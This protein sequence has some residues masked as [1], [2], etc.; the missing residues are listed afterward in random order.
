MPP[1]P[2]VSKLSFLAL[3]LAAAACARTSPT[4]PE[5][6]DVAGEPSLETVSEAIESCPWGSNECP[7]PASESGHLTVSDEPLGHAEV[8]VR[9]TMSGDGYFAAVRLALSNGGDDA[10][11]SVS[12]E[13]RTD[14]KT[15]YDGTL[16]ARGSV[17]VADFAESG[18]TTIPLQPAAPVQRLVDGRSY[19]LKVTATAP[20]A[21]SALVHVGTSAGE[22]VGNKLVRTT[23]CIIAVETARKRPTCK[24]VA[25]PV[26]DVVDLAF[27]PVFTRVAPAGCFD[28]QR[29]GAES[30]VDCGT[31]CA[32][33]CATG[34]LCRADG[35]CATS[36]CRP[37]AGGATDDT[38]CAA[39]LCRCAAPAANGAT[40][41]VGGECSSGRCDPIGLTCVAKLA[42]GETCAAAV[43]CLS[44]R[45]SDS[46]C[47]AKVADGGACS[48]GADCVSGR[49]NAARCEPAS[50]LSGLADGS[51][52]DIDCGGGGC[53]ARCASGKL[54]S[55]TS[56][57]DTDLVCLKSGTK[58]ACSARLSSGATCT[59]TA[60]C[61]SGLYCA[62]SGGKK[63]C[64]AQLSS[65]ATCSATTDCGTGLACFLSGGTRSCGARRS[66][67]AS[68]SVAT[69]CA[70]GLV[71]K[72]GVSG[73]FTCAIA[74]STGGTCATTSECASGLVCGPV[75]LQCVDPGATGA[76]C[77]T[78]ADCTG[79]GI[80]RKSGTASVCGPAA[81]KGGG[82][83]ATAE[84]V[85]GLVCGPVIK[86]CLDPKSSG[87][88]CASTN[89]CAGGLLCRMS[90]TT[91][92]CSGPL[93]LG[94]VCKASSECTTGLACLAPTGSTVRVCAA[95]RSAGGACNAASDCVDGLA[96]KSVGTSLQCA[97]PVAKGAVCVSST[98]CATGLVCGVASK[99]CVD[100]GGSDTPCSANADCTV[101]G[102]ICRSVLP[103]LCTAPLASGA[104]CSV[105]G[106]CASG[107]CRQGKCWTA[108]TAGA[109]CTAAADCAAGFYCLSSQCTTRLAKGAPC[110]MDGSCVEGLSCVGPE[111]ASR[112]FTLLP[113][114]ASCAADAHCASRVCSGG[115]C[116]GATT[117]D[118]VKNGSETDID[119]GTT[120][121]RCG[122]GKSCLSDENCLT[123]FVCRS[124]ACKA[125]V[126][127]ACAKAADCTSGFCATRST[128]YAPLA[129]GVTAACGASA[130]RACDRG[131]RCSSDDDCADDGRC[132]DA[133]CL[134]TCSTDGDCLTGQTCIAG[135]C[136]SPAGVACVAQSEC[137]GAT[138]VCALTAAGLVCSARACRA[139]ASCDDGVRNQSE[140][141]V[142]CGG[143][144]ADGRIGK[145]CAAGKA[146]QLGENCASG[147][148]RS[149]KCAA[150]TCS[151]GMKNGSEKG[152]D[153]GATGCGKCPAGT[154]MAEGDASFCDSGLVTGGAC[155][156]RTCS[157]G[158]KNGDETDVDC[159]GTL[160]APCADTKACAVGRD[161][162][163]GVCARLAGTLKCA[164]PTGADKAR[165]GSETDVDCGGPD[166]T[167]KCIARQRCFED[168]D[169]A[170]STAAPLACGENGLCTPPTCG[171]GNPAANGKETDSDCGGPL[172]W[173]R[174]DAG[175]ACRAGSDCRSGVC[176]K[177]P[178]DKKFKCTE[179][180]D[181]DGVVNGDET[182]IDC[183]CAAGATCETPSA[184]AAGEAC[185]SDDDCASLS[186]VRGRCSRG[187]CGNG[188]N[189]TCGRA[190]GA[191][192]GDGL[193]CRG[194]VDCASGLC[195]DGA[196]AGTVSGGCAIGGSSYEA[197]T[198]D[199]GNAS[200]FCN[201]AKPW[202]W[203]PVVCGDGLTTSPEECDDGNALDDDACSS[204]CKAATC[205]DGIVQSGAGEE[206]DNGSVSNGVDGLCGG[207]CR[208]PRCGD[209]LVT[210]G[211]ECD[212]G[213]RVDGD[214]C[215]VAC[216]LETAC[217]LTDPV[218]AYTC[219]APGT[220]RIQDG[221]PAC[222][223]PSGYTV[224]VGGHA[225]DAITCAAGEYVDGN[226]CSS[227]PSGTRSPGGAVAWCDAI[228]CGLGEYWDPSPETYGC[229]ACPEGETSPGG[230]S[231]AD[232][233]AP[234]NCAVGWKW[235]ASAKSCV[236]CATGY[237]TA[238][239]ADTEC[240]DLDECATGNGGC[241][242]GD[243]AQATCTNSVGSYTCTCAAGRLGDGKSCVVPGELVKR[244]ISGVAFRFRNVP[245]SS[246]Y[247][248]GKVVGDAE[249]TVAEGPAHTVVLTK[250][251]LFLQNEV[252]QAQWKAVMGSNSNPSAFLG[253]GLP[254]ERLSWYSAVAFCNALSAADGRT[255]AYAVSG[256][257]VT[258][259]ATGTGYRLPTEAEWEF[260]A[261]AGTTT[262]RP[263][264]I[265][266][267]V[268]TSWYR[269]TPAS[270]VT[271]DADAAYESA[272][273]VTGKSPNAWNLFHMLGNVAE[274][275]W[276]W[277]GVYTSSTKTDPT[278][279]STGLY[280]AV[281]G[282]S[283]NSEAGELRFSSR[284][285]LGPDISSSRTVGVRPV[286]PL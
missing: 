209:L 33:P 205:G 254:V 255:N 96:C 281:R 98:D 246:G 153:C 39:T 73:T 225:C 31:A 80:C 252:T 187:A 75:S 282:G 179:W 12:V 262:A 248:R 230:D 197:G 13:L 220:C 23:A 204:A 146:C 116:L 18:G 71:C 219:D 137:S 69:D 41:A 263:G 214:G 267:L 117:S 38:S 26:P 234:I 123:G 241:G 127:A 211:E 274:W 235:E 36:V 67:G 72:K 245:G 103:R 161:C 155:A 20:Q 131:E 10:S 188:D 85:S 62:L 32:A 279:P 7:W 199:E 125:D 163:S 249:A 52:T 5:T 58:K 143:V 201:P 180:S 178:A 88:A 229:H 70:D 152:I 43:D 240:M 277:Y 1:F 158:S 186:C 177:D 91:K 168:T 210:A 9:F 121:A 49:C 113:A 47:V 218:L 157:D 192:C 130:E 19:W 3:A 171:D 175:L 60:E 160:C 182:G 134:A 208:V 270:G 213:N 54:C 24:A 212:D 140:T 120:S 89:D 198:V 273:D 185:D 34:R 207:T 253:D 78:S 276:D 35:D 232:A 115:V 162:E 110:G 145:V 236:A 105:A 203:S 261:R 108:G 148:C 92:I 266:D 166:R 15:A 237:T 257:T 86:Q 29:N 136:R 149:G 102:T 11:G 74:V 59:A 56:D 42:A 118:G 93:A 126:G 122:P 264:T 27:L 174:C 167:R 16:L 227:C 81:A 268:G 119:C 22:N 217:E 284:G 65:G 275:T 250:P 139:Q 269:G 226:V 46:R 286:C 37:A 196:C 132:T 25:G 151:D 30:D 165:N 17:A 2:A 247:A 154:A 84:C 128:V 256:T 53:K 223:C 101:G 114:G 111:G 259:A 183:G 97:T 135:V 251:L 202:A 83:T 184:C 280:R 76:A 57:C 258:P 66:A 79:G 61:A 190:C 141:D 6:A 104:T 63:N 147:V 172:C 243:A 142:D 244:T 170:N 216:G 144:C 99:L 173:R 95:R 194:D 169:C 215:N 21:A 77:T 48:A 150:A 87:A 156:R 68:C 40:C 260:A 238:G 193:A 283:W 224:A 221:A 124:G 100:T 176:A 8:A 109:A 272:P 200:Q 164:V 51:E 129:T 233:C 231:T 45:C 82:C 50:C 112:C 242:G 44:G 189:T 133:V 55:T 285:L 239:G 28:L 159:G 94:A 138:D 278:G 64:A 4:V 107:N 106:D 228:A 191:P 195:V 14:A 90:G 265:G 271:H 222:L 181:T 206:C